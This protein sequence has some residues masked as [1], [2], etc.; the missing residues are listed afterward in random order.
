MTY[1]C[2]SGLSRPHAAMSSARRPHWALP[3]WLPVQLPPI[4]LPPL[5]MIAYVGSPGRTWKMKKLMEEMRRTVR[6]TV[7]AFFSRYLR[8]FVPPPPPH[9]LKRCRKP[10]SLGLGREVDFRL[11]SLLLPSPPEQQDPQ[12]DRGR[13]H[14]HDD[15]RPDDDRIQALRSRACWCQ[16]KCH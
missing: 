3:T 14:D 1:L 15:D 9:H 8:R 10:P 7:T 11:H 4:P 2:G 13:N 6:T 5:G 12:E 16:R